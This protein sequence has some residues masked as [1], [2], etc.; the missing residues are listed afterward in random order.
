MKKVGL[1]CEGGGTKGAYTAGV[2]SCFIDNNIE[3]PYCVGISSGTVNLMGYISKDKHLLKTTAIE[4]TTDKTVIGLKPILK[5]G[6]IYGLNRIFQLINEKCPFNYAKAME[7]SIQ[8]ETGL[9]NIDTGKIEYFPKEYLNTELPKA[10]CALLLLS[11]PI[12]IFNGLYMDAGLITMIP[13]ERSIEMGNEKHIFISTKE[14]NFTRKAS[15]KWQHI[16]TSIFYPKHKHVRKDLEKRHQRYEEQ[17]NIVKQLESKQ[18][19][20]ILRPSKDMHIGRSTQDK[21]K[22]EQWFDLG[23][24][25]TLNRLAEIKKFIEE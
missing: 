3:F 2:L 16:L 8:C 18:K 1:V 24:Q 11:K 6:Q 9:Y 25:D 20:M 13:I 5:E 12:H 21:A 19:A 7:N 22:L 23:Y 14:E 17:W 4:I 10:S 15:P